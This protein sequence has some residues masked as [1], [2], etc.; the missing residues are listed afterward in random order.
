MKKVELLAPAGNLTCFYAAMAAG[1]D[2]VY[3]AMQKYGAR[4]FSENFSEE[5]LLEALLFANLHGKKI[6]IT[7]NTLVKDEELQE[8]VSALAPFYEAG[9][10]GVIVQDLGVVSAL[11]KAY[12]ELEIHAST[13]MSISSSF[14][15]KALKKMGLTRV[16]PARELSLQELKDI[17]ATGLEVEVFIHGA[18]CYCYSGQC[19]MSSM[20][21]GRSGNRGRC[22]QP[23]RLPYQYLGKS[24]Q[25]NAK[26]QYLLSLKDMNM[27]QDLPKLLEAGMDSFKIEGR[28]K[29]P[30]YVYGVT[31]LYRK[32]I[33]LLESGEMTKENFAID[34]QD[35][36]RIRHLYIRSETENGYYFRHNG[37]EMVTLSSP[38]Y[39]GQD[40]AL[41]QSIEEEMAKKRE[42]LELPLSLSFQAHIG[43]PISL[44]G[45]LGDQEVTVYGACAELAQKQ[46][47]T[48]EQVADKIN[49]FGNTCF[50]VENLDIQIDPQVFLP[51]S[52]LKNLR[53][54]LIARIEEVRKPAR[55]QIQKGNVPFEIQ[56]AKSSGNSGVYEKLVFRIHTLEQFREI[57]NLSLE[58]TFLYLDLDIWMQHPDFTP[59]ISYGIALPRMVREENGNYLKQLLSSANTEDCQGFLVPTMDGLGFLLDCGLDHKHIL[60][61]SSFYTWNKEAIAFASK[62]GMVTVPVELNSKDV[63]SLFKGEFA[64]KAQGILYGRTPLMLSAGCIKKTADTCNHTSE[65]VYIKDRKDVV[66]PVESNCKLCMNTIWNSLATNLMEEAWKWMED[67][68]ESFRVEFSIETAEEAGKIAKAFYQFLVIEQGK[69]KA[70]KPDFMRNQTFTTGH[71]NRGAE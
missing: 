31:A 11:R 32:Y 37:K 45:K 6:Y 34:S 33:D 20:L 3:L 26:E 47:A 30:A 70:S 17:K 42:M 62:I 39:S 71:M 59:G 40:E 61:D 49:A 66:Y 35:L 8:L 27:L 54:D 19:L 43:K 36:Y 50:T 9:L 22:A 69:E 13:Q 44:S 25:G 57:S 41:L 38:A 1:A 56:H 4:A 67:G 23:C 55:N 63:R 52:I 48:K 65:V 18:M 24:Q 12:P 5:D 21:G 51:A 68:I 58:Q 15:A 2:A 10:C 60:L 29:S 7:C 64:K 14:G 16:V 46:G 53:R 28:M